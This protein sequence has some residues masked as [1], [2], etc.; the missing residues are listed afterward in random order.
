MKVWLVT[1]RRL[2]AGPA[3]QAGCS[4][5]ARKPASQWPR[6]PLSRTRSVGQEQIFARSRRSGRSGIGHDFAHKSRMASPP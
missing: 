3:E 1:D 5:R 4:G 6:A 2:T